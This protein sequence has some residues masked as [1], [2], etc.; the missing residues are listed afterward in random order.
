MIDRS[1][2]REEIETRL[3]PEMREWGLEIWDGWKDLVCD[4]IDRIEAEGTPCVLFQVK[5]KFGGLRFYMADHS[6]APIH[7]WISEAGERS[8]SICEKCGKQGSMRSNKGWY[9]TLCMPCFRV[10]EDERRGMI[11]LPT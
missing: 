8:F 11:G 5:E 4:L 6:S 3:V 2:W 9:K 10:W 7:T 1:R